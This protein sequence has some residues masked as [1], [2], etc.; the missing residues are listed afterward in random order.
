MSGP[1]VPN[2]ATL[3]NGRIALL[4]VLTIVAYGS[5][6]YGFGVLIDDIDADLPGGLAP[7]T[8][9]YAIAQV[10]TGVL[11]V[12]VG[13]LLDR[14]GARVPFAVGAA[15]GPVLLVASTFAVDPWVF[16]LLFGAGGGA[17]GSTAFYH[18]TQAVSARISVGHEAQAIAR[19]T[20]WGAFASP[21]LIPVTEALRATVG[22]RDTVRLSAAVVAVVLAVAAV[23]VDPAG[24]TR[25]SAPSVNPW[26]AVRVAAAEPRIRRLALSTLAG[27]FG[28]SVLVVLQVPA[29]VAGGIE[30]S[31]A[32]GLAGARGFAQLLGRLPL[33]FALRRWSARSTLRVANV[34]VGCGALLLAL[35]TNVA[36]AT[37]FVVVAGIGIGAVSPL[38][39][40]YGREVLP[41]EDLG[42]LMGAL[43]LLFGF[44]AGL[45]PVVAGVLADVTG[46]TWSGLVVAAAAAFVAAALLTRDAP[47]GEETPPISA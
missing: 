45:G 23:W 14:S 38:N 3:P 44:S 17:I 31:T 18:L 10:L 33:G 27:S 2:R 29:M 40:I 22:W 11:G 47:G 7:L 39:G 1:D 20:I 16:A 12:A 13:R 19:L 21:V 9:G 41:P 28:M 32:A 43:Y 6:F 36:T 26:T 42:T 24:R 30:R 4:G 35:S 8:A 34:A 37:V 25:S 46:R 5:W 15:T